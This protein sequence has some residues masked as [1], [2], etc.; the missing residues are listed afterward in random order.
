MTVVL[1]WSFATR[2]R[3]SKRTSTTTSQPG[4]TSSS[5]PTTGRG[6]GRPRSSIRIGATGVAR[7]FRE[8]AEFSEQHE[9][10]T[11]MARLAFDGAR[12]RLGDSRRRRRV[13]VAARRVAAR[14]VGSRPGRVRES[15][16]ACSATSF[17]SATTTGHS[18]SGWS[19]GSRRTAPIN[20]PATP[21]R[22]VVKVA[23]RGSP[24]VV[25]A[26][27]GGHQVFGVRGDQLEAWLS[28]RGPP[29]PA[30][31]AR[32][33]RAQV[34]ED[35]DRL[36]A[37]LRGDLAR[38]RANGRGRSSRTRCGSGSRWTTLP[39]GRGIAEGSLV[40]DTRL[41]DALRAL[42]ARR[43]RR[44]CIGGASERRSSR[45]DVVFS[46]AELVRRQRWV[47]ELERRV[48][49]SSMPPVRRRLRST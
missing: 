33:V 28:A 7:V 47:D 8:E 35:V 1:T 44:A 49:G 46:E 14:R 34:R 22:P 27:G 45:L 15:S 3:S 24:D 18:P 9:W 19:S 13:L 4:S 20:D 11:R 21:F 42:G 6:T 29:L 39:C 43:R 38:A 23:V 10:Q 5:S 32:A 2:R 16:A 41:R 17:R 30:S 40:T 26:E 48:R 31:L 12:G 25:V 37:N 36:G